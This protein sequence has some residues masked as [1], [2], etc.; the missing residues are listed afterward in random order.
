MPDPFVKLQDSE[1]A[2]GTA[3]LVRV[4]ADAAREYFLGLD[5]TKLLWLG[6]LFGLLLLF[7]AVRKVRRIVRRRRP[8]RVAEHLQAYASGSPFASESADVIARR[9]AAAAAIVATSST[10]DITG[11]EII[12]QIEAVYVDGFRRADDAL[13]ALKAAAA[14]KGANAIVRVRHER[15]AAGRCSASGDGVIV[16]KA[17]LATRTDAAQ[18][19]TKPPASPTAAPPENRGASDPQSRS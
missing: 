6:I 16:R 11:Y 4:G 1:S 19:M 12:E 7:W 13:E 10:S 15:N 9:K 8:A 14:M 3:D 2:G 17:V 5:R 18:P